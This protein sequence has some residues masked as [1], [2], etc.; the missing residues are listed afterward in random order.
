MVLERIASLCFDQP[1]SL[2]DVWRR[3]QRKGIALW[4]WPCN[5]SV[6]VGIREFS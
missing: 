4:L 1:V 3:V 2:P 6:A 5:V